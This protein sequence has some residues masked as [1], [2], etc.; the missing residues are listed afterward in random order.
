MG[1]FYKKNFAINSP[2]MIILL[3]GTLFLGL[4]LRQNV[5]MPN[6][7]PASHVQILSRFGLTSNFILSASKFFFFVEFILSLLTILALYF[8]GQNMVGKT[9]GLCAAFTFAV[10]PYFVSGLYSINIFFIFSFVLYLLSMYV[11]VH[12]MSKFWNLISGIFFMI[13]CIVEP[14][15]I[16]LGLIPY[17]YLLIRQK[18][19]AVL[20]SFLFFLLGV[21]LMLGLFTLV[22]SLKGNLANFMPITDSLLSLS[23]GIK[24]F[25]SNPASY[26][27]E[28]IWPYLKNTFAYPLVNGDYSYLHYF[29][30]TLSILGVL[31]SFVH[32]NVR[33]LSI[34]LI[35][36]LLQAFFMP[37][38]YSIIF[39]TLILLASFMVDKVI[40]DVFDL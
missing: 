4:I 37:Y 15:I 6:S 30:I 9:A 31:Y 33:I 5:A 13:V 25:F 20:N 12:S 39:I 8:V 40:K 14:S 2:I 28:T 10:Y 16:I 34:L 18:H 22:A 35:F 17:I 21:I 1:N 36:I 26:I 11:G 19:V 24:A 38:D 27:T 7:L 32:E 29:I 23:N 3:L